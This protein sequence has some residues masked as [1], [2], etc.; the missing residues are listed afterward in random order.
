MALRQQKGG[1]RGAGLTLW[2]SIALLVSL[3][4]T[5]LAYLSQARHAANIEQYVLAASE[6]RFLSQRIAKYATESGGGNEAAFARLSESRDRFSVLLKLLK[7]GDKARNLPA[8]PKETAT[9]VRDVE[10][11]WLALRSH[12]DN[13][14]N[15]REGILSIGD[16]V[17]AIRDQ[18]PD[19]IASSDSASAQLIEAKAKPNQIYWSTRQLFLAQRIGTSLGDVL[20]GGSATAVAVDQL[21][22]DVDELKT[23]LDALLNGSEALGVTA[24]TEAGVKE[25]LLEAGAILGDLDDSVLRILGMIPDVLPALESLGD[26]SV[27]MLAQQALE[28]GEVLPDIDLPGELAQS[29]D[30]VS[31]ATGKLIDLFGTA[32]GRLKVGPVE[33][34]PVLVTILGLVSLA[35][36]IILGLVFLRDSRRREQVSSD[37]YQRNQDAIRRL[38]DE[39]GDLADGDLSVQATVTED[40]TGAIA[41]SINYAIEAMR[42]VVTSINDTAE[43]VSASAQENRA[44]V[45]HLAE[46]SEHQ[47]EQISSASESIRAMS[48]AMSDMAKDAATSAEV[49]SRSVGIAAKGGEAVRRTINGMD[50]IREQIQ[51]TAKRIKR[52]GESSQEIGNIVELIEDIADQTNILALNAAM[53]AAMAGEAGRGFAVVADEVQ[54]LAERSTNA[55]KQIEALVQTI[56]ADTNEAVTS[57]EASTAEVVSGAK[58]A[59]DAGFALQEIEKVSKEIAEIIQ[60]MSS[61][62]QTQSGVA[63][64]L[65]D[66]MDVIQ[67]ITQQ[68]TEGTGNTAAAI[69]ALAENINDLRQ[70]VA[71][72]HLPE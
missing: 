57:M 29:S 13:I 71:G 41:D 27:A 63:A 14:L 2:L 16:N 24:V 37:Q 56:Q 12:V 43:R 70:S 21:T 59:E 33:V 10:N 26:V 64:R 49:A 11:A 28:K 42:E 22:Q 40:I 34:G 3:V 60:N 54:R 61:S 9:E 6:Q 17:D 58:L 15:N 19:L 50:N 25:S 52:L 8:A 53:Q 66:T 44:T 45:M 69:A 67:E 51:E 7:E 72:F 35:L 38:L 62:A 46:A 32:P 4:L 39:M 68:A 31:E 20:S 23:L 18:L 65:N 47:F 30:R 55:T 5:G 1:K 48:S 36:L